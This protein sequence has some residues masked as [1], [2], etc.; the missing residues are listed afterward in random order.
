MGVRVCQIFTYGLA[1]NMIFI[2]ER[3]MIFAATSFHFGKQTD[4]SGFA[5]SDYLVSAYALLLAGGDGLA[6]RF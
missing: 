4:A 6:L 1:G 2:S 5:Y 3:I